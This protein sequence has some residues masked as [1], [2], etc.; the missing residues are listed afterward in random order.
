MPKRLKIKLF[1]RK[2][3]RYACRLVGVGGCRGFPP[4]RIRAA[5]LLAAASLAHFVVP[6]LVFMSRPSITACAGDANLCRECRRFGRRRRTH[7]QCYS[8]HTDRRC[9]SGHRDRQ[10]VCRSYQ[11]VDLIPQVSGRI[12]Q[13]APSRAVGGRFRLANPRRRRTR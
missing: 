13:L 10:R 4:L 1:I 9:S 7:G 8:D 12:S 6:V 3:S 5:R 2:M 11:Y